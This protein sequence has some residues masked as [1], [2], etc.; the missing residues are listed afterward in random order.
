MDNN[1]TVLK[2][3]AVTPVNDNSNSA[4]PSPDTV[5]PNEYAVSDL[6]ENKM[7]QTP[8]PVP[9]PE[10]EPADFSNVESQQSPSLDLDLGSEPTEPDHDS[11][12]IDQEKPVMTQP[13]SLVIEDTLPISPIIQT[14]PLPT[15][16]PSQPKITQKKSFSALS[17]IIFIFSVITILALAGLFYY[18]ATKPVTV[19]DDQV[20]VS[21]KLAAPQPV[22]PVVVESKTKIINFTVP[23]ILPTTS[24]A[25]SCS[26]IS[27]AEPYRQDAF[28]CSV[29]SLLYDPCFTTKDSNLMFCQ[30]NPVS[31]IPVVI[32]LTKALPKIATSKIVQDNWAWFLKLSDGTVCS[33]FT[34][35]RPNISG[36]TGYYGCRSLDKNQRLILVGNLI[37]GDQWT[38]NL[39][40]EEK[41][42]TIWIEKKSNIVDIDS[43]WQ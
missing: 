27:I 23:D 35:T 33:P 42:G 25:G 39:L 12:L 22:K 8:S 11:E 29:G 17:A 24:V 7:V 13:E 15:Y 37:K 26:G 40:T 41:Q 38:A 31:G 43:V 18:Y 3:S 16:S 21:K 30:V 20:P 2:N 9:T 5:E 32:R 19:F 36:K 34:A 1:D 6:S 28:R 4:N 14:P 10:P